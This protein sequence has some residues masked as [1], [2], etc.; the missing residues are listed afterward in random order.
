MN[1]E[2]VAITGAAGKIGRNLRPR[3]A[4]RGLTLRCLVHRTPV[5]GD[6]VVSIPGSIT[7]PDALDALVDGADVVI[8][9]ATTKE[10]PT[11]FFET[12]LRGTFELLEACRRHPPRQFVLCSG[13]AVQGI[14]F[15]PQP[16]PINE[17][18]PLTAYPGY[19]AFSKVMEEVMCRQYAIQYELPLTIVRSSWVFENDDLLDHFSLL[20][21][22]DP[23]EPG[24]GFGEVGPEVLAI[25][26]RGEERIPILTNARGTPYHRHIVHVD[27]LM[28]GFERV[29]GNDA[30]LGE[31]YN[32]AGPA[33]FDYRV[34]AEAIAALTG[35]E[36][37]TICCPGFHSF[38]I[39][40]SKARCRLGYA[41]ENDIFRMAERAV[42]YR[43][44]RTS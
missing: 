19:Y 22:V 40:I 41:P 6:G 36:T 15:Y 5:E 24:H 20:K 30:A 13:D 37:I 8:H 3:L 28:Q 31:D 14:W 44:E 33:A 2:T 25:R 7:D 39:D 42:R 32:I 17:H 34:A 9:L 4:A 43:A 29:I 12:S 23:A 11:S 21:N 38:S 10:D 35:H 26:E 27:D 18:H 16:V 1:I